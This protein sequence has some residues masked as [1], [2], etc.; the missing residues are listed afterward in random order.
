MQRREWRKIEGYLHYEVSDDG[1]V[2]SVTRKTV[3]KDGHP[4][5]FQG[6]VLRQHLDPRGRPRI[7]LFKNGKCKAFT[8]AVLVARAF[9]GLRPDGLQVCH[10]DDDPANNKV[11]NLR[12]DTPAA[13]QQDRKRGDRVM[14][15]LRVS[16]A[17][18]VK[19]LLGTMPVVEIARLFGVSDCTIHDIKAGRTWAAA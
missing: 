5:T 3:G 16:D 6:R 7:Q 13:N 4:F 11:R 19:K 18:R 9:I 1:Q 15:K 17:R 8:V 12:Y 10:N 14:H 2:R